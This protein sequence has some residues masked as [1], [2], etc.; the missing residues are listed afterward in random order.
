MG[1]EEGVV[2]QRVALLQA[3]LPDGGLGS[4]G[5]KVAD[6]VRLAM[7]VDGVVA[8]LITLKEVFPRANVSALVAKNTALLRLGKEELRGS[9]EEVSF[10]GGAL[11]VL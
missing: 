2:R 9:A 11:W 1:V 5:L 10:W 4:S 7:H 6:L 3:V 8:N